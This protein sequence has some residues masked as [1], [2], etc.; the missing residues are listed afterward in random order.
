[1]KVGFYRVPKV[2]EFC[3]Y[4]AVGENEELRCTTISRK[5]YH[6]FL[7]GSLPWEVK[8]KLIYVGTEAIKEMIARKVE[9][10]GIELSVDEEDNVILN[11]INE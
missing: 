8:E 6:I 7:E 3:D 1:M 4:R 10:R 11:I 5:K 2:G 9:S